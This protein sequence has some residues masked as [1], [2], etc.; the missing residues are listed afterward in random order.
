M[1]QQP[2]Q[3]K[4][5]IAYFNY[6]NLNQQP[7]KFK[8]SIAYL[9]YVN[10][11]QQPINFKRSIAYLNYANLKQEPIKFKTLLP[12]SIPY[13]QAYTIL[14]SNVLIKGDNPV[15]T[16]TRNNISCSINVLFIYDLSPNQPRHIRLTV[17]A[18]PETN[19]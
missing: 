1:K 18:M 17:L 11:K 9:N 4:Q 12:M 19:I 14:V 7:I 16:P 13:I 8:R 15:D 5:S 3:F 2:I 10:L 6:V